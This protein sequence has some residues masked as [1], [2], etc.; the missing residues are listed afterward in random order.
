VSSQSVKDEMVLDLVAFY[1]AYEPGKKLFLD[2]E[3]FY[4]RW[5]GVL[6]M[7]EHK[8]SFGWV[9]ITESGFSVVKEA[10]DGLAELGWFDEDDGDLESSYDY[11]PDEH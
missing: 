5:R 8:Q 1:N 11:D 7:C 2:Y 4:T 3:D 10:H 9:E 6:Q